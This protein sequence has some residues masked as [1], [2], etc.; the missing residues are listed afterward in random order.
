[1]H[2]IVERKANSSDFPD[3]EN[4]GKLKAP[5]IGCAVVGFGILPILFF[6]LIGRNTFGLA[7]LIGGVALGVAIF[8]GLML[9][10][11]RQ[12]SE[13]REVVT[14]GDVQEITIDGARCFMFDFHNSDPIL[15]FDIGLD[16]ILILQ[17]Q[18]LME[19]GTYGYEGVNEDPI[20]EYFN[21]L[22]EP[23]SFPS[24]SFSIV[25]KT[26]S[27]DVIAIRPSGQYLKP[28]SMNET[29][30]ADK[31]LPQSQLIPGS[32]RNLTRDIS[33]N[34]DLHKGS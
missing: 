5:E 32:E 21:G 28:K 30:Y 16:K 23:Y 13:Q 1:M 2:S 31:L 14:Q 7:G 19:E 11:G 18:W 3:A 4:I 33:M 15:A 24:A 26:A 22:P 9:V 20:E 27:G 17:G 8:G 12:R 6:G 29:L 10:S 34:T 25:R